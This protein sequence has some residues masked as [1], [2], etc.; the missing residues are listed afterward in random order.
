[1]L[2]R[3][4]VSSLAT[5]T[6]AYLVKMLRSDHAEFHSWSLSVLLQRCGSLALFPPPVDAEVG[7]P[8]ET[9]EPSGGAVGFQRLCYTLMTTV[10]S[11]NEAQ[12]ARSFHSGF[13][14]MWVWFLLHK[15]KASPLKSFLH[16]N[17]CFAVVSSP[18]STPH[19][20]GIKTVCLC[21]WW[22]WIINQWQSKAE[23][24]KTKILVMSHTPFILCKEKET[25]D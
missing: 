8:G 22:H 5:F 7:V 24:S 2:L 23:N 21:W 16:L 18:L 20:Y 3:G 15:Q 13:T 1:M 4:Q 25:T 12:L 9:G 10:C 6:S 17:F 14:Q 11:N 19:H